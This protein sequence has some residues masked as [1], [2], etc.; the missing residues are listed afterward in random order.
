[1]W[2]VFTVFVTVI[3]ASVFISRDSSADRRSST[4]EEH[5]FEGIGSG[6]MGGASCCVGVGTA[7][8]FAVRSVSASV[9]RGIEWDLVRDPSSCCCSFFYTL[10][11]HRPV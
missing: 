10:G 6:D 2:M 4:S 3:T 9:V 5:G 1:M 7:V 8:V 11:D